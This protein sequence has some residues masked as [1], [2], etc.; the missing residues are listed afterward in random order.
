MPATSRSSS[1]DPA[2]LDDPAGT[3]LALDFDGTLAHIVADPTEA[4]AHPDSIRALG[5]LGH[6]LGTIAIITGRP[7]TQALELGGFASIDGLEQLVIFGQYGA[8]RWNAADQ[9]ADDLDPRGSERVETID[10]LAERLPALLA[11][12]GAEGAYVEDKGLALAV[13]TRGL[14]A[15]VVKRLHAPLAEVAGEM[16]LTLEPGRQVLEMR[17]SGADKGEALRTIVAETTPRTVV[18]AGDDLGDLPAYDAVDDLRAE[19]LRG[20]LI[21]SASAE[22]DAL[23]A[24]ADAVL[25]G[26]D[27]IATWLT[28]WADQLDA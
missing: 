7:V 25:D 21:C 28:A 6:H 8:E 26:P 22:Q 3:L 15:D 23:V 17:F 1:A 5:R 18:F 12:H 14:G 16:G 9:D 27:A 19:G 2:P 13:H 10:R 24:R 20:V 4:F 11:Q